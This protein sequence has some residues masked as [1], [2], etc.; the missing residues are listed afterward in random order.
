[1]TRS[2]LALWGLLGLV[3]VFGLGWIVGASGR[4]AAEHRFEQSTFRLELAEARAAILD[5]RVSLYNNNFGD[6]SRTLEQAKASL[7]RLERAA[8]ERDD[9][10]GAGNVRTAIGRVNEAQTLA[11]KLDPTA[12]ARAADALRALAALTP[13]P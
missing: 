3:I 13:S 9:D 7:E 2:R 1:M 12:N 11:N 6:A 5:A 10:A 8:S 4:R